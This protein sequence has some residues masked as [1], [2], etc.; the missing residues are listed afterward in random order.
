[1]SFCRRGHISRIAAPAAHDSK[2]R[3]AQP[4]QLHWHKHKVRLAQASSV[5]ALPASSTAV[6]SNRCTLSGVRMYAGS[7][8]TKCERACQQPLSVIK[9]RKQCK[10]QRGKPFQSMQW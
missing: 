3:T 10:L 9:Q 4:H 1:M 7:L 2:T 5:R 6:I 8:C